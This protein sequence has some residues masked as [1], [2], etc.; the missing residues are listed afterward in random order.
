MGT[1][2]IRVCYDHQPVA[3]AIVSVWSPIDNFYRTGYTDNNGMI[4]FGTE[5]RVIPGPIQ[6]TAT[7]YWWG[8]T[9]H[10]YQRQYL[11]GFTSLSMAGVREEK[12]FDNLSIPKN[13][14]LKMKSPNPARRGFSFVCGIP[15]QEK[16]RIA[17]YNVLGEQVVL[18]K[19]EALKPGYYQFKYD[20]KDLGLSSGIYWLRLS[21]GNKDIS[22]KL[23]ILR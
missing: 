22:R 18:L 12:E 6:V 17:L 5:G 8:G 9:A 2:Y 4:T 1:D 3:S 20:T 13:L 10:P 16:T 14:S 19:D 23:I 15:R 21:Q 11:P 7:R